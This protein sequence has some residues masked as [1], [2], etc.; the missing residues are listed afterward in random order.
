MDEQRREL[1]T[2]T[3]KV[4]EE[5]THFGQESVDIEMVQAELRNMDQVLTNFIAEKERMSVEMRTAPRHAAG[6]G[7]IAGD[8][9]CRADFNPPR[10]RGGLMSALRWR[11]LLDH[12]FAS[13]RLATSRHAEEHHA[14]QRKDED[15]RQQRTPQPG[16]RIGRLPLVGRLL[17]PLLQLAPLGVRHRPHPVASGCLEI[18]AGEMTIPLHQQKRVAQVSCIRRWPRIATPPHFRQPVASPANG[19][20]GPIRSDNEF[21]GVLGVALGEPYLPLSRLLG[22]TNEPLDATRLLSLKVPINQPGEGTS[23]AGAR[24]RQGPHSREVRRP[25]L[26]PG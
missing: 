22:R 5:A 26:H 21:P 8:V 18:L 1:A 9:C 2:K 20:R 13:R 7:G 17:D 12:R 25:F 14:A 6:T 16:V 3:A 4:L 23:S 19:T 24:P 11:T 15:D 10:S